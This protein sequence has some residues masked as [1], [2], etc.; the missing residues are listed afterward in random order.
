MKQLARAPLAR[1]VLSSMNVDHVSGSRRR[2]LPS[3]DTRLILIISM[4]CGH[5]RM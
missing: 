2:S 3:N 5:L 4:S 1:G